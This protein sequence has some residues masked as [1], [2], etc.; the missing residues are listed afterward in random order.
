M[1]EYKKITFEEILPIWKE[2]LWTKRTSAIETHSAIVYSTNPYEYDSTYFEKPATFIGAYLDNRLV[3]V[4]SGHLTQQGYYRS[5]G[6]YV[7]EEA[8][9]KSLGR[10]LLEEIKKQA[11]IE[12][13]DV[14]W[15]MPRISSL[16]A[17]KSAGFTES[18]EPFGTETS[19]LNVYAISRI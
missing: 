6:L 8:R 17:Y 18:S 1:I 11:A 16:P 3:G 9:G 12:G 13:A 10:G 19:D 5:R 4:N 7:M 2:L 14:C 15:S